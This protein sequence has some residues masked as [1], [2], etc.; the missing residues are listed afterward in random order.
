MRHSLQ[1]RVY[2]NT[3]IINPQDV[4]EIYTFKITATSPKGN[5]LNY[6]WQVQFI[7]ALHQN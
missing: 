5:E 3:H 7:D 1:D 4:F 6:I 2:L